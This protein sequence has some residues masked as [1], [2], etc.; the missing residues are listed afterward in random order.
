MTGPVSD[1]YNRADLLSRIERAIGEL[2]RSPDTVSIDE[3]A[4]VEEFHIGARAATVALLPGLKL[5]ED[6]TA[7]DVG[8]GTGG[9]SRFAA[10]RYGCKVEGI[11]L[12]PGF[13]EA[14]KAINAWLKLSTKVH[15][16]C[17][18]ALDMSFEDDM[19][20]A[21]WMFH[22]GMNIGEKRELFTGVFRTLKPG[23]RFLVYDIMRGEDETS[24]LVFPL[25]WASSAEISHVRTQD[26][27]ETA[28]GAAGFA[29]DKTVARHDLAGP[30]FD[31]VEANKGKPP[32]PLSTAS[33]MGENAAEKIANL[34]AAYRSGKIVPVEILA[35]KPE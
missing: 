15:L 18:S 9:V 35:R 20:D 31:R 28:L 27:Y 17:A 13:I 32:P 24:D 3:L 1:H 33:L 10:H 7:L 14:G 23:G 19:F 29:I 30:F 26:D 5:T 6:M 21:A 16:R 11:D 25:P 22:V 34:N 12:T 2:G 4:P 8:C